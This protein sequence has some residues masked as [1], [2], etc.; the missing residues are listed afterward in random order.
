MNREEK[1]E[2]ALR[3]AFRMRRAILD[4]TPGATL[5]LAPRWAVEAFDRVIKELTGAGGDMTT[6]TVVAHKEQV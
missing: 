5:L 4:P 6:P 1:L 3:A 2:I